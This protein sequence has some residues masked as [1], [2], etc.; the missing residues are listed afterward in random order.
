M[1]VCTY[2]TTIERMNQRLKMNYYLINVNVDKIET[3]N[4]E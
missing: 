4:I 3:Y 1:Y 2:T